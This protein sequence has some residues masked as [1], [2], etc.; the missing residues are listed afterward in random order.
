L[1]GWAGERHVGPGR[2]ALILHATFPEDTA[3]ASGN[4]LVPV[5]EL[6]GG[7]DE[8]VVRTAIHYRDQLDSC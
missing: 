1:L 2:P 5:H 4:R 7:R 3:L 6:Q 8:E